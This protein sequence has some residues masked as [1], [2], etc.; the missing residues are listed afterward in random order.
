MS[1]NRCTRCHGTDSV[2]LIERRKYLLC[3]PFVVSS[4]FDNMVRY[5]NIYGDGNE[6]RKEGNKKEIGNW[7]LERPT[8]SPLSDTFY[9]SMTLL[10]WRYGGDLGW[11]VRNLFPHRPTHSLPQFVSLPGFRATQIVT[12][13]QGQPTGVKTRRGGPLFVGKVSRGW[14]GGWCIFQR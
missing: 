8:R 11:L 10:V 3:G 5:R 6:N 7:K 2:G 9:P 12:F 4:P 13:V 14:L 1:I